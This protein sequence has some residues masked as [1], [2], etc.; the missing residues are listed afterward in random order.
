[1]RERAEQIEHLW[2]SFDLIASELVTAKRTG[3]EDEI[4]WLR[5][6]LQAIRTELGELGQHTVDPEVREG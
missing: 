4:L 1:M 3:T 6:E 5:V 2:T